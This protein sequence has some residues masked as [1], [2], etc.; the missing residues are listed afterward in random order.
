MATTYT[1]IQG[2]TWDYIAWKL[3]GDEKFMRYLIEANW[4]LLE[5][6]VFSAGTEITVPDLPDEVDEDAP[7]WRQ[8]E[9]EDE[10][11]AGSTVEDTGY[12]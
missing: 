5:T 7:F 4:Q 11:P 1:T 8:E 6:L 12:E 3:Y 10:V 9:E 2:D